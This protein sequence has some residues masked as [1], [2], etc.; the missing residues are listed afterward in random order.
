MH[1]AATAAELLDREFLTI[2]C[3][4]LEVAA[5][6]DRIQRGQGSA[7]DDPRLEKIRETLAILVKDGVDRAE[8]LQLIFSLPYEPAWRKA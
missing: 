2:R 8:Q 6:L 7:A 5:A 1:H 3:K 4:L